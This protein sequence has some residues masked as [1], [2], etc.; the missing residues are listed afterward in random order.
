MKRL[1]Q[2]L[3]NENN[4]ENFQLK[5]GISIQQFRQKISLGSYV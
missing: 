3:K 2:E 1:P 5:A 4:L